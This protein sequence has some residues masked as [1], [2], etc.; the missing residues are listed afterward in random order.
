MYIIGGGAPSPDVR[1]T[2]PIALQAP[3]AGSENIEPPHQFLARLHRLCW[4]H[5]AEH[6]FPSISIHC[7][8][9]AH[10]LVARFP[11]CVFGRANP[12]GKER[13]QDP[14]GN[15]CRRDQKH[16]K[17]KLLLNI[18]PFSKSCSHRPAAGSSSRRSSKLI[19]GPQGPGYSCQL[20]SAQIDVADMGPRF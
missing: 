8:K 15:I 17:R 5:P 9:L 2:A 16:K 19:G 3:D 12:K 7:C 11:S 10:Q 20:D 1:Q 14:D 13:R 18:A 6:F 4:V